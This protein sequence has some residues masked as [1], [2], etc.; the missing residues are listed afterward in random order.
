MTNKRES[1]RL[2][3]VLGLVCLLVPCALFGH[4]LFD[5][6]AGSFE[7]QWQ[8]NQIERSFATGVFNTM[9]LR[10]DN[11]PSVARVV[12]LDGESI[13]KGI[14]LAFDVDDEFAFDTDE[15]I[16]A[17]IDIDVTGISEFYIA[18][19]RNGGPDGR[20]NVQVPNGVSG[21]QTIEVMLDRARFANR[22]FAG[23][24]FAISSGIDMATQVL[25]IRDI[26]FSRKGEKPLPSGDSGR[27]DLLIVDSENGRPLTVQVGIYD[28]GNRMPLP[29]NGAVELQIFDQFTRSV[30]V[31]EELDNLAWPHANRYSFYIEGSYRTILPAG[32]Y[33][34]VV[35]KGPEYAIETST[36]E[37]TTGG[38]ALFI[39]LHGVCQCRKSISNSIFYHHLDTFS[40][41][42]V[43]SLRCAI[44]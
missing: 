21:W 33:Q 38:P 37:I 26:R 5:N 8:T 27:L 30:E 29:S 2:G 28:S 23:T 17:E 12:E 18:Y 7:L 13:I 31:R 34:L 6:P 16:T 40:E 44:S 22:G 9:G 43:N 20:R 19:D 11:D 1:C 10:L 39:Y 4:A 42:A 3:S 32:E 36:F 25:A 24:D 35:V 41:R 15:D 14:A